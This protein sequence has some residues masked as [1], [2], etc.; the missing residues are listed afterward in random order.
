[1]NKNFL[2]TTGCLLIA[3]IFLIGLL[4]FVSTG[5]TALWLHTYKVFTKEKL[6]AEITVSEQKKDDS[7]DMYF[8]LSYRPV[9]DKSALVA[10][11]NKDNSTSSPFGGSQDFKVYGD[12]FEVTGQVIKFS[13]FATLLGFDTI[14]KVTRLSGN[15]TDTSEALSTEHRSIFD[16]NGGTDEGWKYMQKNEDK[17]GFLV[18][19]VYGSSASKFVQDKE[20]TYGLYITEDGFILE[21]LKT[22][23]D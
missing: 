17:L 16:I 10:V 11:F 7:G 20:Q 1:M 21:R 19:T 6:V 4:I 15:Y 22:I 18:E 14:Y 23:Q 8:D 13:N 3:V 5:F 9:E 2:K 12:E